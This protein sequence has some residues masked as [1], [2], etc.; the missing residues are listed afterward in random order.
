MAVSRYPGH[1]PPDSPPPA[2]PPRGTGPRPRGRPRKDNGTAPAPA[3]DELLAAAL[4]AFAT[5]GYRG[6]SVRTLNRELGV[7][8]NLLHQRY[9]TKEAIW[10]AAVDWG[11]GLL[12]GRLAEHLDPHGDPSAQLR[13]FVREFV[14]FSARHPD[15]LRVVHQ[16]GSSPSPRLSY[17]L[18]TYVRP[19]ITGLAPT[20]SRLVE[21]GQAHPIP[22]EAFYY[23]VTSGGGAKHALHGM[24]R[25]LFGATALEPERI[26]DYAE[27]VADL[28]VRGMGVGAKDS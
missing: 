28:I 13:V 23:L 19:I 6:V 20:Y 15:L 12:A 25:E 14:A 5:H 8:H 11:F 10:Y 4:H 18:D 7:S 9:G 21:S 22:P 2:D 26:D 27:A 24:T 16:E 1:V 17:L 3:S